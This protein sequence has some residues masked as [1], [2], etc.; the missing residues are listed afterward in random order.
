LN[1]ERLRGYLDQ[2]DWL[3]D[4]V[5]VNADRAAMLALLPVRTLYLKRE[6]VK[7]AASVPA[8]IHAS[9]GGRRGCGRV[10]LRRLEQ[11]LGSS[12]SGRGWV[13]LA[14]DGR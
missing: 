8:V 13:G 7:F 10:R 11:S 5:L 1:T 2:R 6:L 4:D 12:F 14:A 3:P 9:S